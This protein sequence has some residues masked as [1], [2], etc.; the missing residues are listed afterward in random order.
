MRARCMV[1]EKWGVVVEK[2]E[3]ACRNKAHEPQIRAPVVQ[4]WL[5]ASTSYLS[6]QP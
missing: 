6:G 5:S 2:L 3:T 1:A 4:Y